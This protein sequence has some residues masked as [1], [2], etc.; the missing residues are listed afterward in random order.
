M[1]D[2]LLRFQKVT[3]SPTDGYVLS[4]VDGIMKAR[5][6]V[7]MIPLPQE[8]VEKSLYGRKY[9]GTERTT[10]I[11]GPNGILRAVLRKVKPGDHAA[12]VL[13]ALK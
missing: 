10:F 3:L 1:T 9:M 11:I 6:I 7:E 8:E 13:E 4:R 5:D 12:A 2:P